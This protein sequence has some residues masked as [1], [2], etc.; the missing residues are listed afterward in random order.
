MTLPMERDPLKFVVAPHIVEDLGLNLYT[1]LPRVLVEFIANAYD[2]DSPSARV[3]MEKLAIDKARKVLKNQ[4]ELE[5]AEKE[6]TSER[7]ESLESRTLPRHLT[8]TVEDRGCGMSRDDLKSKFLVAGRRRRKE[9]PEAKGRTVGNR[10][11]MGR[12]GLGKLAGFGVAKLVEVISRKKGEA[13]ATR[14]TL[15]YDRLIGFRGAHEI[16]VEEER[17]DDGAGLEPGGTRITLSRLL[18]DQTKSKVETIAGEIA[19]HFQLIDPS[20]FAITLNGEPVAPAVRSHAY[21]WPSPERP[22]GDLVEKSLPRDGGGTISFKYRLRFTGDREA[23]PGA[24]RGVRV[25]ANKRLAAT[26]SLLDADTNMH[27]FRMTDYLDGVVH[28]DFIAEEEADYVATDRQSLRWSSPLLSGM[29]AFLSEQ[30]KEACKNYQAV[31]DQ[32]APSIVRSDDF[33]KTQIEGF[34]FSKKD[35]RTAYRIATILMGGYKRG[36][37]DPGYKEQFPIFLRG[38]GHGRIL[39]EI[40]KLADQRAP[41]LERVAAELTKLTATELEE[42]ASFARA[43]L[44]GL[45]ALRKIVQATDFRKRQN[46]KQVQKMFEGSPWLVDPT[47]TQFLSADKQFGTLLDLL[48]KHLKIGDYAVAGA[49]TS[50]RRPDLIF[51]VGNVA[52]ARIVIVELK[53]TNLELNADHLTQLEDYIATTRAWL[54]AKKDGVKVVGQL[55]GTMPSRDS[56]SPGI[57]ALWLRIEGRGPDAPWTVRDYLEVMNDTE[58]AHAELLGIYDAQDKREG[59]DGD[60]P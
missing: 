41:D 25:Y 24:M 60:S 55:I 19:D 8:I 13:H 36:V 40:S 38:I 48:A 20:E 34:G 4:Y 52:L 7:V 53:S 9:E 21:A 56:Q 46:E 49:D 51:L 35:E 28:A 14:I 12:K 26:P 15:D 54:K 31:R 59:K 42:F 58:A 6:G 3:T 57:P 1:S 17:L 37:E 22:A 16:P 23:L 5:K 47:Y 44:R 45:H 18:Y 43:R 29:H 11:L 10:P 27:G 30:I 50:D 39:T 33:T 2:A 32:K